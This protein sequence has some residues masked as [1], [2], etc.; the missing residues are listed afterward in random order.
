M[1]TVV[2]YSFYLW[3]ILYEKIRAGYAQ[4]C[5]ISGIWIHFFKIIVNFAV[6]NIIKSDV[7]NRGMIIENK[8][9]CKRLPLPLPIKF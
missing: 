2:S 5:N 7:K 3:V 1:V 4:G 9:L 8:L 6:F